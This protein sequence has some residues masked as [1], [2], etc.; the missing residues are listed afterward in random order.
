MFAYL[1]EY[2]RYANIVGIAV[3]FTLAWL[4]S[5]DRK[6]INKWLMLKAFALQV[7]FGAL[8][9]KV[10]A[11]EQYVLKPVT[12]GMLGLLDYALIGSRFI[13]GNLVDVRMDS[14]GF[15]FAFR[16]LPLVIFFAVLAAILSHYGIVKLVVSGINRVIRPLLGT[17]GPETLSVTA[18]LVLDQTSAP[19]LI[20]QYLATLTESQ[21]FVVMVSGMAHMSVALLAVYCTMGVP[22]QHMLIAAVMGIP[23][24]FVV[25]KMMIPESNT[26]V[27]THEEKIGDGI[28]SG[29]IFD[30]IFQGTS[31][32]TQLVMII[33]AMLLVFIALLPLVDT[34]ICW[35][36]MLIN[37]LLSFV[38]LAIPVLSLNL[39][40]GWI[41][42][43]FAYLM[44]F[45]GTELSDAAYLLGTK[46]SINELVAFS[47]LGTMHFSERSLALITYAVGNFANFACIGIQ[48]G[49]ISALAPSCRPLL[50]KLGLRAVFAGSLVGLLS[51]FIMGLLI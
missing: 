44:G 18:N 45:T 51:A 47:R 13:F 2:H 20:K 38:H 27:A 37:F 35:F 26:Q 10:P 11:I 21:L 40:F 7:F 34:F 43:P 46:I 24:S 8:L 33:G 42:S 19:I 15:V 30:A 36:S 25:A 16:V 4:F 12:D 1:V 48:V 6:R 17:T 28:E 29:N 22:M 39:I 23:G 49:G 5:V 32:G 14:W 41:F 3:V 31:T 50:T 9:I